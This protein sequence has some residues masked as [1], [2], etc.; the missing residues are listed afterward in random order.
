MSTLSK[1]K[2]AATLHDLAQLLGYSPKNLA[3]IIYKLE[4]SEKYRRFEIAKSNG[5]TRTIKAPVP[6]LKLLQSRLSVMLYHSIADILKTHPQFWRAAHGFSKERSI[7]TNAKRHRNKRYVFNVDIQDFFGSINFGRVRGYFIKD[8]SFQLN[9]TIA[10]LI[11]QISCHENS[12]PQGS[13]SSPVVSNLIGNLIDVRLLSLARQHGCA[14]SR[15]ADDLT[16]STNEQIFP[17]AIAYEKAPSEW[18]LGLSLRSEIS[19]CGFSPNE[20][21]TRISH[22]RKRQ[23]VTGLVVNEKV[24]VDQ[25]YV[26]SA[27]AMCHSLFKTGTYRSAPST[28]DMSNVRILEGK[29]SHIYYVKKEAGRPKLDFKMIRPH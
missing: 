24:N 7:I 1:L 15:Y 29:L 26:R 13:P 10:T 4:E 12:L 28:K 23:T 20:Q 9:P 8:R 27:R 18:E 14:Y 19:A 6:K 16:F 5:G 22:W 2:D 11:A 21:K 25:D 17:R 3:F